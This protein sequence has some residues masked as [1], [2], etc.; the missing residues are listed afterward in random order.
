[1]AKGRL[2]SCMRAGC[3]NFWTAVVERCRRLDQWLRDRGALITAIATVALA[4]I[5]YL[6]LQ[7]AGKTRE[8]TKHMAIE[9]KRLADITFDQFKI[10]SYPTFLFTIEK[11]SIESDTLISKITVTN[12]GEITTQDATFFLCYAYEKDHG[13]LMFKPNFKPFYEEEEEELTALD[14]SKKILPKAG[15]TIR[16]KLDLG[17]KDDLRNLKYLVV[18]IRFKVPYNDKFDYESS[19]YLLKGDPEE[20]EDEKLSYLW[21]VLSDKDAR[22]VTQKAYVTIRDAWIGRMTRTQQDDEEATNLKKLQDFL[23][24]Y[25]ETNVDNRIEESKD[26]V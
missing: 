19:V 9:T 4:F 22:A 25:E 8:A 1:M 24:D 16:T 3:I 10:A 2:W 26:D 6:Y 12:K 18:F 21:Q 15:C 14:F 7:E 11:P 20:K 13:A 5:T 17:K 23:V